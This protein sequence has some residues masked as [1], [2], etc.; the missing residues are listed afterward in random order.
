MN[1]NDYDIPFAKHKYFSPMG[2]EEIE[3]VHVDEKHKLNDAILVLRYMMEGHEVLL[4]GYRVRLAPTFDDGIMPVI[5][6]EVTRDETSREAIMGHDLT[7]HAFS[8]SVAK[9][10]R[11]EIDKIR[12]YFS[13][14]ETR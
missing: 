14:S 8:E 3:L 2:D 1:T 4:D 5:I 11:N 12:K 9:V 7:I 10:D 6:T 13:R